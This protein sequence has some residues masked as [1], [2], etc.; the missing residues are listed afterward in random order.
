M[1][2]L[3]L[4][5]LDDIDLQ[6]HI[7]PTAQNQGAKAGEDDPPP[8]PPP[9]L[10]PEKHERPER[11][12]GSTTLQHTTV[13]RFN[14]DGDHDDDPSDPKKKNGRSRARSGRKPGRRRSESPFKR[15]AG[16]SEDDSDGAPSPPRQQ[17]R[18]KKAAAKRGKKAAAAPP[19]APPPTRFG[20]SVVEVEQDPNAADNDGRER[21]GGPGKQ[22]LIRPAVNRSKANGS[23]SAKKRATRSGSNN[24]DIVDAEDEEQEEDIEA[25]PRR[26][27]RKAPRPRFV[28]DQMPR[29]RAPRLPG[30][31]VFRAGLR[32]VVSL[33]EFQH[34]YIANDGTCKEGVVLVPRVAPVAGVSPTGKRL[35]GHRWDDWPGD[36]VWCEN[37]VLI[38]GERAIYKAHRGPFSRVEFTIYYNGQAVG[39]IVLYHCASKTNHCTGVK[40]ICLRRIADLQLDDAEGMDNVLV[41][42]RLLVPEGLGCDQ[43][44]ALDAAL[45]A[46]VATLIVPTTAAPAIAPAPAL[47]APAAEVAAR[48]VPKKRRLKGDPDKAMWLAVHGP[49][50]YPGLGCPAPSRAPSSTSSAPPTQQTAGVTTPN[51]QPDAGTA[52]PAA[53]AQ[54]APPALDASPVPQESDAFSTLP[55]AHRTASA[56]CLEFLADSEDFEDNVAF[57]RSYGW[58]LVP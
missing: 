25:P 52:Y 40:R 11:G 33:D 31:C 51:I 23:S 35:R 29:P 4:L 13:E 45:P 14:F 38:D 7:V 12:S 17:K 28:A 18:P 10:D 8:S 56:D 58:S 34:A 30:P 46:A 22:P 1:S 43:H 48:A 44:N 15:R 5:S 27:R 6:H 20:G 50:G 19:V 24:D 36:I 57:S 53:G 55:E 42:A 54:I 41:Y 2:P 21:N 39:T 26:T 16:T 37:H 3:E 49:N 9:P 32:P 47:P